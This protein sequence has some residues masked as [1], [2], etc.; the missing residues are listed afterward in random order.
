MDK[1]EKIVTDLRRMKAAYEAGKPVADD[2]A[3]DALV[4]R[5]IHLDPTH[6]FLTIELTH[7]DTNPAP[8]PLPSQDKIFAERHDA[9]RQL[10]NKFKGYTGQIVVSPKANGIT[11]LLS[12][13]RT[14]RLEKVFTHTQAVPHALPHFSK[15][16]GHS[17]N[18]LASEVDRPFFIRGESIMLDS[19]VETIR[20]LKPEE[21]GL[22]SVQLACLVT[23]AAGLDPA[24]VVEG[25]V[26]IA[27]SNRVGGSLFVASKATNATEQCATRGLFLFEGSVDALSVVLDC[28]ARDERLTGPALLGYQ[29]ARRLQFPSHGLVL[30]Q[31][32]LDPEAPE[33][34]LPDRMV[35]ERLNRA[36]NDPVA[37]VGICWRL[38]IGD[39]REAAVAAAKP[40]DLLAITSGTMNQKA[41]RFLD[42]PVVP[43]LRFFAF[44]L[45]TP[46]TQL[47]PSVQFSMLDKAGVP[48]VGHDVHPGPTGDNEDRIPVTTVGGLRDVLLDWEDRV[49]FDIDGIVVAMNRSYRITVRNPLHAFAFKSEQMET[50]V[51]VTVTSVVW[52]ASKDL[53]LVPVVEFDPVELDGKMVS[54]ATGHNARSM[55]NRGIGVGAKLKVCRSGKIIPLIKSVVARAKPTL[56]RVPC[57]W[58]PSGVDLIQTTADRHTA[59]RSL[60]HFF[61]TVDVPKLGERTVS[62]LY[63]KGLD[64]VRKIATATVAELQDVPKLGATSASKLVQAIAERLPAA[65]LATIMCAS[66]CFGPGFAIKRLRLIISSCPD[67]ATQDPSLESL[68]AIPGIQ[69]KTAVKFLAGLAP[70]RTFLRDELPNLPTPAPN[71]TTTDQEQQPIVANAEMLRVVVFTGFRDK[72]MRA[73]VEGQGG[74]IASNVSGKTTL[75]VHKTG[76]KGS[77][78]AKARSIGTPMM[79]RPQFRESFGI[80]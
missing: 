7:A 16:L 1:I 52:S 25:L 47:P 73:F 8:I 11:I 77:K 70:F 63:D 65:D 13:S 49:P 19:A 22:P 32:P 76:A 26:G 51:E 6:D 67:A 30:S 66:N 23:I 45:I 17:L 69:T 54:K 46:P 41:D 12:V 74:R 42:S 50:V 64:S 27:K 80:K 34:S 37:F 57:K 79:T 36:G 18:E 78:I 9:A 33:R 4:R 31:T 59:I 3:Y 35:Y 44:E 75:L 40:V 68:T 20:R 2:A 58:S 48:T 29:V 28:I 10:A 56:P 43:L 72:A 39:V 24:S 15:L 5:L 62:N 53:R 61:R 21:F 38:A 71:V 14:G 55:V 60:V